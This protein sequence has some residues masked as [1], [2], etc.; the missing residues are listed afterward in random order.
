MPLRRYLVFAF[1]RAS[2]R[3][4]SS[5]ITS[6]K[7]GRSLGCCAKHRLMHGKERRG[8]RGCQVHFVGQLR[9]ASLTA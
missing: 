9:A 4:R 3:L 6:S 7:L 1:V 2:S 8:R 5:R